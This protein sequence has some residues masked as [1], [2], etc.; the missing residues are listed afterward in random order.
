[1]SN[2]FVQTTECAK[3][4]EVLER[5][6]VLDEEQDQIE[7]A[8]QNRSQRSK[9]VDDLEIEYRRRRVV[10]S[11]IPEI[12]RKTSNTNL[13]ANNNNDNNNKNNSNNNNTA[14]SNNNTSND[15]NNNNNNN[16]NNN[17]SN[18]NDDLASIRSALNNIGNSNSVN[19]VNSTNSI[20]ENTSLNAPSNNSEAG[21]AFGRQPVVS[22][23]TKLYEKG[24]LRKPKPR[25]M[26]VE[27]K[28]NDPSFQD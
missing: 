20:N 18:V 21:R 16:S 2:R 17:T 28:S 3:L 15:N 25:P 23:A 7:E 4:Y 14:N 8:R 26:S 24:K 1:M 13:N 12:V 27:S 11:D 22:P 5:R 9:N 19:S 6:G 10:G